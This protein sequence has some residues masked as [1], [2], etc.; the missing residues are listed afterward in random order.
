MV[1]DPH[2]NRIIKRI[3]WAIPVKASGL[4]LRD[5]VAA[6]Y[7]DVAEGK[8]PNWVELHGTTTSVMWDLGMNTKTNQ[9]NR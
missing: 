1:L 4:I 6:A 8:A 2:L 7:L 9:L 5:G 3:L